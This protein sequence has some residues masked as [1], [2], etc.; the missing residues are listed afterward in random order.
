[1]QDVRNKTGDYARLQ[2]DNW[3]VNN[4]VK[5]EGQLRF[6]KCFEIIIDGE[7]NIKSRIRDMAEFFKLKK[8][9]I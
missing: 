1:M 7:G 2:F 5:K 3:A 4:A 9:E 8:Q 6:Y